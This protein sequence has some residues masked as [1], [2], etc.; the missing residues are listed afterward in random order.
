MYCNQLLHQLLLKK[1]TITLISSQNQC[2]WT[3]IVCKEGRVMSFM[4]EPSNRIRSIA[5]EI[6]LLKNVEKKLL[7]SFNFSLSRYDHYVSFII[8]KTK[9]KRLVS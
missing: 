6:G 4:F 7:V 2:S 5:T 9:H 8:L 3:Q 1:V